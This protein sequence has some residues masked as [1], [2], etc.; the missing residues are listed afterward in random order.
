DHEPHHRGRPG[1]VLRQRRRAPRTRRAVCDRE[2]HP[3]TPPAPAGRDS[4]TN[5]GDPH[6]ARFRRIRRR[7]PDPAL[8]S[9]PGGRRP[10]RSHVNPSQV[11]I[12]LRTRPHGPTR[13]HDAER[14][15]GN[16]DAR[17][18]HLNQSVAHLRV[19]ETASR[20]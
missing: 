5:P 9:L 12:A 8:A 3:G 15:L 20:V 7:E 4:R 17:A 16:L 1:R 14:A 13:W 11:C 10:T 19:G 2:L 18:V 6:P